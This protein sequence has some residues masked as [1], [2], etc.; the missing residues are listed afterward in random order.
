MTGAMLRHARQ[1]TLG[2]VGAAGQ[3]R[4]E[5]ARAEVRLDGF[6]ARVAVR[7]LAGAGVGCLRVQNEGLAALARTVDPK[8]R[9]EIDATLASA[10][11]E[12]PL[13]AR[14]PA[15][16]EL[17]RGAHCALRALRSALGIGLAT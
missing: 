17:A 16:R 9:I 6:A 15:A 10:G 11:D 1:T 13:G 5:D 8:V 4:I 2:E 14:D 3:A 12:E 7:Y